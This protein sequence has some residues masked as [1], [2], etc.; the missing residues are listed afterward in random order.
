MKVTKK[1]KNI[2]IIMFV[3]IVLAVLIVSYNFDANNN[4][5]LNKFLEKTDYSEPIIDEDIF[6]ENDTIQ[7][8]KSLG[9]IS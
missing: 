4:K 6:I 2:V 5:D 1:K 9:Y 3:L 7:V 8:L